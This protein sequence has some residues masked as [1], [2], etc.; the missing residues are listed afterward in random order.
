MRGTGTGDYS[1]FKWSLLFDKG[2][3]ID[4]I[5]VFLKL[6]IF[7]REPRQCRVS[8][9][10]HQTLLRSHKLCVMLREKYHL[11]FVQLILHRGNTFIM[12]VFN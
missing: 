1:I 2:F 9:S 8:R 5:F 6:T 7:W 10:L 11:E 4:H 12:E 3:R